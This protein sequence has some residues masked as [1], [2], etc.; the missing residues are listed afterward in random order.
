MFAIP[1]EFWSK[2]AFSVVS[3]AIGGTVGALVA[4][5]AQR[6]WETRLLFARSDARDVDGTWDGTFTQ[7]QPK[8]T[9]EP[10]VIKITLRSQWWRRVT[11]TIEYEGTKL[12]C[13]G[14]FFQS[15]I[16][17]LHYWTSKRAVLQHGVATVNLSSDAN[18]L[19]GLFI[20]YGPQTEALIHGA[21]SVNR[22]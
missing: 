5:Y 22:A 20:G 13:T 19:T 6:W 12:H 8:A 1:S 18:K 2:L 11:G 21:I 9:S 16:L 10:I 17:M 14:G 15:R 4:T 7:E 3:G